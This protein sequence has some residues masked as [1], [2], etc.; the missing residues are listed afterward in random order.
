M[1]R[2][3]ATFLGLILVAVSIGFNVW[4]YPSLWPA[5]GETATA[6][7]S[8]NS[9]QPSA[10][11]SDAKLAESLSTEPAETP[12]PPTLATQSEPEP[13]AVNQAAAIPSPPAETPPAA[14]PAVVTKEEKPL[15][16][17]PRV[18]AAAGPIGAASSTASVRRLP[19]V[20]PDVPPMTTSALTLPTGTI[21]IYPST[22][23]K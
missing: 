18:V 4:R 9:L 1:P 3:V 10:S 20:E 11:T 15:V 2:S 17:V 21:P 23:I 8:N 14:P 5:V 16:P 7:P 13:V 22:G 12:A 19:P 6:A